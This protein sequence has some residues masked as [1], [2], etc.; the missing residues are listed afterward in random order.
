[1]KINK[2]KDAAST[3][4]RRYIFFFLLEQTHYGGWSAPAGYR[5][6]KRKKKKTFTLRLKRIPRAPVA[7]ALKFSNIYIFFFLI[8]YLKKIFCFLHLK[9][10]FTSEYN[11]SNWIAFKFNSIGGIV[12]VLLNRVCVADN[13]NNWIRNAN[14]KWGRAT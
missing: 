14:A 8:F 3:I 11:S 1:M 12:L 13:G 9:N 5:E 10:D 7:R 2:C 4:C 6:R